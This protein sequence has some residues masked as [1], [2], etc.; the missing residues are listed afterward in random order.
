MALR[1]TYARGNPPPYRAMLEPVGRSFGM[2]PAASA[3]DANTQPCKPTN[4]GGF[5]K[6]PQEGLGS[7]KRCGSASQ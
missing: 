6:I 3:R 2:Q 5:F 4:F 1:C 7:Q